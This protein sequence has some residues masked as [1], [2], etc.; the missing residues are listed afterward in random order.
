MTTM[1]VFALTWLVGSFYFLMNRNL[2]LI[3]VQKIAAAEEWTTDFFP[4]MKI[5]FQKKRL[6]NDFKFFN[7]IY[8][9]SIMII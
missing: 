4:L 2:G 3:N 7:K 5:G 1:M 9:L 6:K 8:I